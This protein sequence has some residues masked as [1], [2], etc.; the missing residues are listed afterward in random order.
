M[1]SANN[2]EYQP[3][4]EEVSETTSLYKVIRR[5]SDI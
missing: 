2:L 3:F 4:T 5:I 1:I